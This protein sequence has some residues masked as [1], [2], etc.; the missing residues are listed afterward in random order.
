MSHLQTHYSLPFN[1]PVPQITSRSQIGEFVAFSSLIQVSLTVIVTASSLFFR[2]WKL[3]SWQK[4]A[5]MR[6]V[7]F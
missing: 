6:A 5:T 1:T 7:K 3:R 4:K 2:N